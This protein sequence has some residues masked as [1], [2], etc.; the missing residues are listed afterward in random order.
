MGLAGSEGKDVFIV[1]PEAMATESPRL[2]S[3]L[4][5][6]DGDRRKNA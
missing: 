4:S 3:A 2:R 5:F 6:K 1:A